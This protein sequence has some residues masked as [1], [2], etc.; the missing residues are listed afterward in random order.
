MSHAEDQNAGRWTTEA[1]PG[2]L[3]FPVVPLQLPPPWSAPAANAPLSG[4]W[5]RLNPQNIR[6]VGSSCGDSLHCFRLTKRLA[7]QIGPG[8]CRVCG[9]TLISMR[10]IAERDI[11]DVDYTFS[12]LQLEYVRH[13]FW[14]TPLSEKAIAQA[15]TAARS[16]L[17]STIER[18]IRQRIG[19]A[20]PYHDGWQ[21]PTAPSKATAFD[22]AMHAVAACC[23]KCAAY[24]HGI[25]IG[26]E[27]ADQDLTY[28]EQL[29]RRYLLARLPELG[30][31]VV[32][33]ANIASRDNIHDITVHLPAPR[34]PNEVMHP[35]AS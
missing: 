21:T 7:K 30:S 29:M 10:R 2:T 9:K 35:H 8:T 33:D 3:P 6:C 14:H 19:A 4:I 34:Q 20:E 28:L 11:R 17:D 22:Y 25:P 23:R 26:C 32:P 24:W 5:E 15:R 27:L 13:Y 31:D 16:G 1:I 18:R 12:A